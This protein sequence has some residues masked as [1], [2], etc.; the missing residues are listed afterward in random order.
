MTDP[1]AHAIHAMAD[2]VKENIAAYH[3]QIVRDF[4]AAMRAEDISDE[5]VTRVLN[6][7]SLGVPDPDEVIDLRASYPTFGH[8]T[9]RPQAGGR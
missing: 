8:G 4:T 6:R 5:T 7:I 2:L 9:M 3:Q 1:T